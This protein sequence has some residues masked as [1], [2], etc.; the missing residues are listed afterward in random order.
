MGF[1]LI[2]EETK[3]ERL[4]IHHIKPL[5]I[6]GVHKGYSNKSL[7]HEF[8]HKRVHQIFGKKQTT[9]LSFRKF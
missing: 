5:S 2:G 1:E 6:S 4:E 9:K 3:Q 8:C 7:L